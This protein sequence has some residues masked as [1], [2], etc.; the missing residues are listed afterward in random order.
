MVQAAARPRAF[1]LALHLPRGTVKME[2]HTPFI[3]GRGLHTLDDDPR[4]SRQL[5]VLAFDG[6]SQ[7]ATLTCVLFFLPAPVI[8]A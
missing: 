4:L 1:A 6:R 7:N 8:L 2:C 5:A 3:L